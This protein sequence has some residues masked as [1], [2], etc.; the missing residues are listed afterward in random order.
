MPL[1]AE[2][3]IGC[4]LVGHLCSVLSEEGAAQQVAKP[5]C[6]CTPRANNH[7]RELTSLAAKWRVDPDEGIKHKSI[8]TPG[9]EVAK[10]WLACGGSR[11][12]H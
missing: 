6:K 5:P 1:P 2:T 10:D 7:L 9:R 4:L 8:Q 11:P 3:C 12:S